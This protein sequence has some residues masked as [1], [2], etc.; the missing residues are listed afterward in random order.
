MKNLKLLFICS[1]ELQLFNTL[2]LKLHLF[3]NDPSDIVI[4]FLKKDT[5]DFYNRIRESGIFENVCYRL[6]DVFGL[7]KYARCVREGDFSHSFADAAQ[8]SVKEFLTGFSSRFGHDYIDNI[9]ERVYNIDSLDF[10]AYQAVFA[11]G[12]ND[13]V[14]NIIRHMHINYPECKIN[15]YEE[16]VGCYIN[17]VLGDHCGDI[18]RDNIY[19]YEPT[20]PV[21]NHPS[22][23]PIPKVKREDASFLKIANR[24][25]SYVPRTDKIEGKIVYLD[26][27]SEPLPNYLKCSNLLN[28]TLFAVP[29]R[30]HMRDHAIYLRQ[31]AIYN[32]LSENAG[33]CKILVKLHPR[34]ER[35]DVFRDYQGPNT[36]IFENISVPWELFCCNCEMRNNV[37]VTMGS[38]AISANSLVVEGRD[39]N[40]L[41]ICR[42]IDN[43]S[44]RHDKYHEFHDKLRR[45]GN[46]RAVYMPNTKQEYVSILG[47]VLG[48][49]G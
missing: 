12:T 14:T 9:R 35:P 49:A 1:T 26:D 47:D 22:L 23:Q 43:E 15:I 4:Q 29:Y 6:P 36:E 33:A 46:S 24:I 44:A 11:G 19:L 7:H 8:N 40:I 41:I 17:D 27:P 45:K 3:P 34:N 28:H 10:S 32:L 30:R 37:F 38:A 13:I 18:P 16:G 31:L 42:Q 25:F 21:Y 20:M 39:E 2:N 48:R 5:V